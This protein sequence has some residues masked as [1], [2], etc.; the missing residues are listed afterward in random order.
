MR[1][2]VK[3]HGDRTEY[4]LLRDISASR[5]SKMDNVLE[6]PT[7][8]IKLIMYSMYSS[9]AGTPLG[10]GYRAR[11]V[12]REYR[13]AKIIKKTMTLQSLNASNNHHTSHDRRHHWVTGTRVARIVNYIQ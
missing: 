8:E 9:Y 3:K 6:K 1:Q 13:N 10:T 7:Y 12:R 11:R 4:R 2:R 5:L